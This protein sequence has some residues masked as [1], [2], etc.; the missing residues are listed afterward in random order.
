ML[1]LR[2]N[3]FLK[4]ITM[5]A[6]GTII[7]QI[8]LVAITPLLTRFYSPSDFGVFSLYTATL[9]I[10]S[11]ISTLRYEQAIPLSKENTGAIR[12]VNLSF[13]ILGIVSSLILLSILLI[14]VL[15]PSYNFFG[16]GPYVYI[17]PISILLLG[18]YQIISLW[19]T[20]Q[21]YYASISTS[22]VNR[23]IVTSTIQ[24]IVGFIMSSPFGL[25]V[26]QVLGQVVALYTLLKKIDFLKGKLKFSTQ[27]MKEDF[28]NHK[29]FP[30]YS[31]P[32]SLLNSLSQNLPSFL[33]ISFFSHTVVGYYA[34]CLKIL[35]MPIT[36]VSQTLRQVYYQKAANLY[37]HEEDVFSFFRKVT[38][39]LTG[40]A[41]VPL[42]LIVLVGPQ[43][44]SFFLGEEWKISGEYSRWVIMWLFFAIIN[45]PSVAMIYILKLQK[46]YFYYD[47]ALF[48]LRALSLVIGGLYFSSLTTIATYSIVGAIMNLFLIITVY[49]TTNTK[50]K[51]KTNV[52]EANFKVEELRS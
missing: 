32:Q 50:A 23:S 47:L 21:E 10:I 37:N 30:V 24:I 40:V 4:N 36:I 29:E 5:L 39:I 22:S 13:F 11:I 19:C 3:K 26:G 51:G 7:S 28:K 38:I 48:I 1:G 16:V 20:K 34:M 44:F 8:I 18:G 25:I 46:F 45:P 9:S 17:V 2:K 6:S 33:L 52:K 42:L 35:Q 15:V 31:V 27:E 12:I 41:I 49:I 14:K 43:L